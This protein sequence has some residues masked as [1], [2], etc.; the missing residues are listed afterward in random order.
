[1]KPYF[2]SSPQI[3]K[4]LSKRSLVWSVPTKDKIVYLTFDD[5]PIP[6]VTPLVLEIL[7]KYNIKAT[8]FCVGDNIVKYPTVFSQV[9]DSGHNIGNHTFNHLKGW[10]TKNHIYLDNI[11]K[12][13]RIYQSELFRPPYGK[14]KPSQIAKLKDRY[15][16]IL[17]SV[18]SCDFYQE[19]NFEDC[20]NIAIEG[21][22]PGSIVVFHDSIKASKNM[23]EALPLYIEEMLRLGYKFELLSK[24]II[25]NSILQSKTTSRLKGI[26]KRTAKTVQYIN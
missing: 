12:F 26:Y 15:A 5:G 14:I 25:N 18:L 1:M 19:Y 22:K 9:L 2:S 7:N 13:D 6:E 4:L 24:E 16:I 8:F 17:W 3:I 20:L 23:L 10:K 11:D 21:T